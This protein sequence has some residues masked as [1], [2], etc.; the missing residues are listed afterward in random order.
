MGGLDSA[1]TRGLQDM[2]YR[3]APQALNEAKVT[4]IMRVRGG[5]VGMD[6]PRSSGAAVGY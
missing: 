3:T 1:I 6:D 5:Y 4:A 2:G